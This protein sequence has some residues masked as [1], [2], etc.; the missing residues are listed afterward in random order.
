MTN[1]LL[2]TAQA[3]KR[4][5]LSARQVIN[6]IHH[7]NPKARLFAIR[8]GWAFVITER[9]LADYQR[10]KALGLVPGVGRPRKAKK[11]GEK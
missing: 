8:F 9:S 6:L 7:S 10:R 1:N 5:G 3:G 4:L 2:T 11:G